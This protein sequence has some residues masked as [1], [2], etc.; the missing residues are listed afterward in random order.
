MSNAFAKRAQPIPIPNI[1][2]P[3]ARNQ[4]TSLKQQVSRLIAA[5]RFPEPEAATHH[6]FHG[7]G[8]KPPPRLAQ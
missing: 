8:F 3:G 2:T 4:S 7:G 5:S 1:K 6:L